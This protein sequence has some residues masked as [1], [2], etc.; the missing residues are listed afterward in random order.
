MLIAAH[1]TVR[2][3]TGQC[4][5]HCPVCLAIGLTLQPTVGTQAF[6]TGQSGGLLY[7]VPPGTSHWGY[8]SLVH[9]TIRRVAPDNIL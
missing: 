4:T 1:R 2:W 7:I 5:I 6:Y 3:C 9:R 8:W